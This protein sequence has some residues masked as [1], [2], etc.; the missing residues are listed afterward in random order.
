M[1]YVYSLRCFHGAL[2]WSH[3][4]GQCP[5]G[6]ATGTLVSCG[7][8]VPRT[9]PRAR[10]SRC[11]R[12][13]RRERGQQKPCMQ[14]ALRCACDPPRPS[15]ARCSAARPLLEQGPMAQLRKEHRAWPHCGTRCRKCARRFGV[16]CVQRVGP[17]V[18]IR[19]SWVKLG[20]Q[21]RAVAFQDR[22]AFCDCSLS[23]QTG[24]AIPT[25]T[26]WQV[27]RY[28]APGR[29]WGGACGGACTAIVLPSPM[30]LCARVV[31]PGGRR[32]FRA[33]VLHLTLHLH[34]QVLARDRW[35]LALPGATIIGSAGLGSRDLSAKCSAEAF[36]WG[37]GCSHGAWGDAH[38]LCAFASC[39]FQLHGER[40]GGGGALRCMCCIMTAE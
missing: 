14:P 2:C 38:V 10:S 28:G 34:L 37:L 24:C 15:T 17:L 11:D 19:G 22:W 35:L 39:G 6:R 13:L 36:V 3:L 4:L 25:V 31:V 27:R 7:R 29:P 26:R 12:F 1:R 23:R 16:S 40:R 33:G 32:I 21:I 18:V 8:R 30:H 9:I 5:L 20:A